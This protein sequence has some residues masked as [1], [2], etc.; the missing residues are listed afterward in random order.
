MRASSLQ[1]F[2]V[3]SEPLW[4]AMQKKEVLLRGVDYC[5]IMAEQENTVCTI[6]I[7]NKLDKRVC[8]Y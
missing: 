8:I 3:L 5:N 6:I 4:I 1:L 2:K 7:Y